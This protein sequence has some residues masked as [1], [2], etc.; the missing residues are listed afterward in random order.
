MFKNWSAFLVICILSGCASKP[1]IIPNYPEK[2]NAFVSL[3]TVSTMSETPATDNLVDNSQ[4]FLAGDSEKHK[5]LGVFGG[6]VGALVGI[7]IDRSNNGVETSAKETLSIKFKK[8]LLNIIRESSKI[9][10]VDSQSAADMIL[11]PSA[12]L[13]KDNASLYHIEFRLTVR[14]KDPVKKSLSTA[15]YWFIGK[16]AL[17][18]TGE[19]GW[20]FNNAERLK[21]F[22]NIALSSLMKLTIKEMLGDY[23]KPVVSPKVMNLKTPYMEGVTK[24]I[25]RDTYG[26][27]VLVSIIFNGDPILHSKSIVPNIY[28][29]EP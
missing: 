16:E 18:I 13:I 10:V 7:A 24:V 22:S 26:E 2:V 20:S 4:V 17:P 15:N 8:P 9:N 28:L 19:N 23:R 27:N 14:Y 21:G 1:L 29:T 5:W 12:R 25:Y 3:D 6:G 11:L